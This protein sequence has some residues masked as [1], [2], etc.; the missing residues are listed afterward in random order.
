MV[1]VTLTVKICEQFEHV[2]K[3][4]RCNRR[5]YVWKGMRSEESERNGVMNAENRIAVII[6]IDQ[7]F[8]MINI[9]T[10]KHIKH[11]HNYSIK[12]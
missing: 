1:F 4:K 3:L 11:L 10:S 7:A 2:S 5:M 8:P 9:S 12:I 6:G